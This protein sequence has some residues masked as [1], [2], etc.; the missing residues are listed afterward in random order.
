VTVGVGK[1][2]D[3]VTVDCV[4]DVRAPSQAVQNPQHVRRHLGY[5]RCPITRN[6]PYT[7]VNNYI[8]FT[9]SHDVSCKNI[10]YYHAHVEI[11]AVTIFKGIRQIR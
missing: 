7:R 4:L 5:D 10:P 9:D 6:T 8:T 11:S 2:G 3:C 1:H